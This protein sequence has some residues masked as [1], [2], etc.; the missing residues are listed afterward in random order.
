MSTKR[1]EVP[2]RSQWP[3]RAGYRRGDAL[4]YA[5]VGAIIVGCLYFGR[6]IAVPIAIALVL[7][8]VLYPIVAALRKFG[9]SNG[10]A[11]GLVTLI[12]FSAL[13]A[14]G[15]ALGRQVI[16][17]AEDLPRYQSSLS[18]KVQRLRTMAGSGSTIGRAADVVEALKVQL[19]SSPAGGSGTVPTFPAQPT[20]VPVPVVIQTP[21]SALAQLEKTIAIAAEPLATIAFVFVSI[22]ILLLYREDVRD[23]A[24]RLVGVG[25][26]ELTRRAMDDAG[27]RLTRY[28][29][30]ATAINAVFGVVIGAGLWLIGVP[31]PLLWGVLAM[32]LR[33][34]P[35]AGVPLSAI[36]PLLLATVVDPGWTKMLT[37]LAL[38]AGVEIIVSQ[39]VETVFQGEATGLSP[40][41]LV[42][43]ATFWTLLW[44]P[45][46][47]FVA[48]PLTVILAVAGRHVQSFEFLE[49]LL[50]NEPALS[51][52][53]RFY[54]RILAG[55]PE[56]AAALADDALEEGKLADYYDE[57]VVPALV[58]ASRDGRQKK[59]DDERMGEVLAT[60][61]S[62][63]SIMADFS[64]SPNTTG[65]H[66]KS[67]EADISTFAPAVLCIGARAGICDIVA[68]LLSQLL[69]AKG[70]AS[71]QL[72]VGEFRRG[73]MSTASVVCVCSFGGEAPSTAARFLT[74]RLRLQMPSVYL[75]ACVQPKSDDSVTAETDFDETVTTLAEALERVAAQPAETKIQILAPAVDTTP[76]RASLA[77]Q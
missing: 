16:S 24:I 7:S 64:G 28:F 52:G 6:S 18:Q 33:F 9:L 63:V 53:D 65:T 34:I 75:L 66:P 35:F 45:V 17:L 46:G 12:T 70:V 8:F 13:G 37:T 23:R 49:V 61:E 32:L 14:V 29:Q 48:I 26:L 22:V 10:I 71:K 31:N 11:V 77:S 72:T 38:F 58:R 74:R 42:L 73:A 15:I 55:E 47:L 36:V 20:V 59:L 1:T 69:N 27:Q 41:A 19:E 30:A 2:A 21:G 25:D 57:V 40:M 62:F 76:A 60:F 51:P 54:H 4:E 68:S 50:G 56:E 39:F 67:A 44:G 3:R 43:A 5:V